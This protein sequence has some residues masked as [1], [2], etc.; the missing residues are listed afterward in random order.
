MG[1]MRASY[2]TKAGKES[3]RKEKKKNDSSP[4]FSARPGEE[5]DG[6][7]LLFFFF[8]NIF[9]EFYYFYYFLCGEP[10]MGY[11]SCPLF[12]M[13]TEQRLC[14]VSDTTK[15]LMFSPKCKSVEVINNPTRPGSN[16]REVN[17]INYK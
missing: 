15:R 2:C 12:T 17:C 13:L 7:V 4:L 5:D 10:K 8:D 14:V 1:E 16:H 9:F 3:R 6:T 11:N